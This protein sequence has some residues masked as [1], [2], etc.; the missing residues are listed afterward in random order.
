MSEVDYRKLMDLNPVG[1]AVISRAMQVIY[2]NA[3]ASQLAP[4]LSQSELDLETRTFLLTV[5]ERK[6]S[7]VLWVHP[8]QNFQIEVLDVQTEKEVT[9]AIHP[10]EPHEDLNAELLLSLQEQ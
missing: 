1:M 3:M 9:C 5:L 10:F 8:N 7:A 2:C 4:I 6:N